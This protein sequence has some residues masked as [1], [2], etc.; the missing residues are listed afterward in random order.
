[1]SGTIEA[2]VAAHLA[3]SQAALERFAAD[4]TAQDALAAIAGRV[5][6]AFRDG[7]RL[8]LAGNGGSAADAQHIAAEFSVRFTYE[9]P[10]LAA[11]AL[12]TDSSVLTAC[13]NDYG[14]ERVFERQ[15]QALGRP[16]DVFLGLSTSGR[17]ANVLRALRAAREAGLS[18]YGWTGEASPAMDELC[19]GVLRVASRDTAVI[20][21]VHIVAGHVLCL[22]V[23]RML[24]PPA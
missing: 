8:L 7:G 3:A 16:G 5:A 12:T 18:T 10:A 2:S 22:R 13:G 17:S 24:F 19:D 23:E 15:V 20:Q 6:A 11:I 1:M 14:F 9:R 21:Q 4:A